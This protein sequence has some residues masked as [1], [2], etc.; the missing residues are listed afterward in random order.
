MTHIDTNSFGFYYPAIQA[1]VR[2]L[3]Y[4]NERGPNWA[5]TWR[6]KV[7]LGQRDLHDIWKSEEVV[8]IIFST[9]S[10]AMNR[11]RTLRPT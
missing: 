11:Y 9:I 3:G 10:M 5:T 2:R 1:G 6:K 8:I 7:K 4:R